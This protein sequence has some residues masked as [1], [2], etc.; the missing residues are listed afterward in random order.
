MKLAGSG[1]SDRD[2]HGRW[3]SRLPI[4]L[5]SRPHLVAKLR[6]PSW[7]PPS[8]IFAPIWT[9]LYALMEVASWMVWKEGWNKPKVRTEVRHLFC[10][11]I[12]K[13]MVWEKADPVAT[14]DT[15]R[16]MEIS[17]PGLVALFGSGET[18]HSGRRVCEWIMGRLAPPISVSILETPAGFQPNSSQ[19]AEKIAKFFEDR[20]QNYQPKITIIPARK[21]GS[22]FSPD[23]PHLLAPLLQ[24]RAFFLGPGSPTYAAKQ[25]RGSLAWEYI[26]LQHSLGAAVLL[27]SAATIAASRYALPVYEIYKAGA[28]LH[29]Q[30]GLDFFGPYGLSLV[31]VPHWDNREG[32]A[33][34][35][36][37]RAYMGKERFRQLL[38]ILPDGMTIVGIDEHTAL[39]MDLALETCHVMGRG[40]VTLLKGPDEVFFPSGLTF[41]L[42]QLGPF[43]KPTQIQGIRPEVWDAVLAAQQQEPESDE[44]SREIL[45]QVELREEARARRDWGTADHLREEIAGHGWRILDTPEGPRLERLIGR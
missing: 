15:R 45:T 36:T 23:D 20:L 13:N 2:S 35:D 28:D 11:G 9:T 6:K 27:A 38:H 24:T 40:G 3:R 29:W 44:P 22:P 43:R 17:E 4:H 18:S 14:A 19:V 37:S 12:T 41:P 26:Q 7:T 33:E 42:T 1:N 31:F 30:P 21:S 25:L 34:L 10:Q 39:V 32:G 16:R 5:S 8:W